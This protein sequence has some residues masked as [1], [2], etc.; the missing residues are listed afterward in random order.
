M[1]GYR[2]RGNETLAV[3]LPKSGRFAG[4]AKIVRAGI[5]A[6]READPVGRRPKLSFYD[7]A[8]GSIGT[9]VRRAAKD[10][11]YLAIGPLQKPAVKKLADST[12]LPIPVL[13]LN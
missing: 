9:L 2:T 12:A 3:L 11:V 6:T 5:I 10:G 1:G 8:A 13:T 4:V 7:S